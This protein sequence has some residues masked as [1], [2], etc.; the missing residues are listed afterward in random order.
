MSVLYPIVP[1]DP[2]ETPLSFATRLAS[3]HLR[4]SVVPFLKDLRIEPETMIG[5]D[6]GPVTHL[7]SVAG[8]DAAALHHNS[9][10]RVMKRRFS[11]RG[12]ELSSE[13][14]STPD[15]VFC[16]ACLREDDE[17]GAA[18]ASVRRG[19]IEWTLRPVTTCPRHG[20]VLV[21]R[22]RQKWDDRYHELGRRVP[23]R[24]DEL[25]RL[26]DEAAQ[27]ATSPLQDYVLARLEG[28]VGTAWLDSQPLEQ[29]VLATERLGLL[30]AFG[31][32][33]QAS[34]LSPAERAPFATRLPT[35][36]GS[37]FKTEALKE[38][39]ATCSGPSTNGSPRKST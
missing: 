22:K 2:V 5:C 3:F 4:S 8:V 24:G 17:G 38:A 13:F 12:N 19:R 20:L 37:F 15:T 36:S 6:E 31:P 25:V 18:V 10:R 30:K 28:A 27:R 21:R 11:L 9:A 33:K 35:R 14:F 29:A 39:A 34:A 23:E 7:A 16:P 26:I 32:S 1:F